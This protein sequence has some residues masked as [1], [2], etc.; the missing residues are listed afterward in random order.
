MI[1]GTS[2]VLLQVYWVCSLSNDR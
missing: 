2:V 1:A